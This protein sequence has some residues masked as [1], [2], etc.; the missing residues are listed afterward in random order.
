MRACEK[1][2]FLP[3][4]L[5]MTAVSVGSH[6]THGKTQAGCDKITHHCSPTILQDNM[7]QLI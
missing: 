2:C 1:N 6:I 3:Q 5:M 4:K 7:K